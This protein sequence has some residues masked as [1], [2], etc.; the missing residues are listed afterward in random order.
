MPT[1]SGKIGHK[2]LAKL[3]QRRDIVW[4]GQL[5]GFGARRS[6]NFITFML[7]YRTREG[8][9]RW[10]TIGRYGSPWTPD[11]ARDEAKR[12]LY[13]VARGGDPAEVKIKARR[14]ETVEDLCEQYMEEAASGLLR[15]RGGRQKK[16]S[17]LKGDR[18][19]ID[20]HVVPILGKRSVAAVTQQDIDDFMLEVA[21]DSGKPT[22]SR[23]V[24]MLGA[25]FQYAVK[26]KMRPDNPVRGVERF[27]DHNRKR[28]VTNEEYAAIGAAIRSSAVWPAVPAA[29]KFLAL[30]GWRSGE[31]LNL[32]R[33][34]VDFARGTAIL[35][36]TK[37]GRSIRPL[38]H[39]AI[40]VLKD[41]RTAG[42]LFF[43]TPTGR[44]F[45]SSYFTNL[46]RALLGGIA[47]DV[48][49]HVLRHSFASLANDLGFTDATVGA[50]LG[51]V[52]TT[53]TSR[54]Q[55]SSDPVLLKAADAVADATAALMGDKAPQ[56]A[57]VPIRSAVS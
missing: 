9:Q 57:V 46:F 36:D 7:M 37:T 39:R 6:E 14:A 42:D 31:A 17:T 45:D 15:I 5:K 30:T 26:R 16:A 25:I 55:H 38:S 18:S 19:R 54:Y 47:D 29:A 34:D 35:G 49:P 21:R 52:G 33:A 8:R 40:E 27:A 13:E 12:L 44:K 32:R 28:R 43:V 24:G 53:M 20:C 41:V 10:Y 22:A 23:T 56:G 4:D 11:T 1:T 51:H 48:T 50:L 2:E 3:R